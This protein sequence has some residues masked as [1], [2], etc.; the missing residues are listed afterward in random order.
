MDE[1][2]RMG[3]RVVGRFAWRDGALEADVEDDAA[4]WEKCI[5]VIVIGGEIV[6]VGSCKGPLRKRI[7]SYRGYIGRSLERGGVGTQTPLWK[8]EAW[9]DRLVAAGGEGQVWARQG[10]VVETPVARLNIFL[11]EEAALIERYRPPLNRSGR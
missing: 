2:T 1:L 3:F 5:Y 9:R 4:R 10:T 7:R 8:A 6:R 11:A